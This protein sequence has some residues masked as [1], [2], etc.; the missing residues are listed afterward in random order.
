MQ[1]APRTSPSF[2]IA[3]VIYGE[4]VACARAARFVAANGGW[5]TSCT[6]EGLEIVVRVEV[7]VRPLR[8]ITGRAEAAARAGPSYAAG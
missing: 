1:V 8:G 3:R 4:A 5:M 7:T 6:V 2:V